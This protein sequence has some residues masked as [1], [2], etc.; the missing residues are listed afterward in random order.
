MKTEQGKA[1]YIK[2]SEG[3]QLMKLS[4]V[5]RYGL[6]GL[7]K[8]IILILLETILVIMLIIT[9]PLWWFKPVQKLLS[10]FG[11]LIEKVITW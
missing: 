5:Y 7:F 1:T 11:G 10:N 3:T 6:L 8:A 9:L 4:E 2:Q